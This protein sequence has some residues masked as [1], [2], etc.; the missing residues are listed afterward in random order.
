MVRQG[1]IQRA[2]REK[3]LNVINPLKRNNI[4][5][6]IKVEMKENETHKTLKIHKNIE[7]KRSIKQFF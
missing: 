1:E 6:T 5:F 4:T 2:I 3:W 7:K